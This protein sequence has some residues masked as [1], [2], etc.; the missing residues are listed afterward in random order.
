[1]VIGN[2]ATIGGI[3][4][5]LIAQIDIS[6]H[7]A[8]VTSWRTEVYDQPCAR[9]RK[10]WMRDVDISP[11]GTTAYVVSSGHI[12]YPACDSVNSFPMNAT[13]PDVKPNWTTKIGDTIETVAATGTG[14]YIGGHFRYIET[15]T[16]TQKH[17]Q[18]A[19]LDPATGSSLNWEPNAGGFLGVKVIKSLPSGIYVGSDGDTMGGVA[20]GRFGFFPA[21]A[22]SGL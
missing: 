9:G 4:R 14:V 22:W 19:V 8:V 15:E 10:G 2:F 6:Q 7:P 5:P 3:D 11:D 20:H 16:L 12:Y 21:Q 17:F 18:L 13:G 1:M